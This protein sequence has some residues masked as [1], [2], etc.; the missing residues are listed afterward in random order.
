MIH[1]CLHCQSSFFPE[2][3]D[4]LYCSNS[5][6]QMAFVKRQ[7]AVSGID[8]EYL[9]NVKYGKQM[10]D[11]T[12]INQNVNNINSTIKQ[13]LVTKTSSRLFESVNISP[14]EILK[15][16]SD[17]YS[18]VDE[19]ID[20]KLEELSENKSS[21]QKQIEDEKINSTDKNTNDLKN[22]T[23]IDDVVNSQ[24]GNSNSPILYPEPSSKIQNVNSL[25]HPSVNISMSLMVKTSITKIQ[26]KK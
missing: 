20:L 13:Q 12:S 1:H 9:Q 16:K 26:M 17:L 5:C 19:I 15:L 18:Y 10:Q 6:K 11:E 24:I 21:Q 8:K 4:K 22:E 14:K 2:R 23:S 3:K 25:Y 7:D